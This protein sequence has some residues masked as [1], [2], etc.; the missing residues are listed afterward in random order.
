MD[1]ACRDLIERL[2]VLE[3]YK[4]LG[5]GGISGDLEALIAHPYFKG[6]DFK[7][8][9]YANVPMSEDYKKEWTSKGRA[10]A[11]EEKMMLDDS[12]LFIDGEE[13]K[14]VDPNSILK[15]GYVVKKCGWFFWKKRLL[16]MTREPSLRYYDPA[17]HQLKVLVYEGR[18]KSHWVKVC[19]HDKWASIDS[20]SSRPIGPGTSSIS[21]HSRW[22]TGSQLLTRPSVKNISSESHLKLG[23][24]LIHTLSNPLV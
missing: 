4:R 21:S 3:P 15:E 11:E 1:L 19:T 13:E 22:Q 16:R 7:T 5:S 6:I 2:V 14:P 9:A 18:M 20:M 12:S 17:T 23:Y 10:Q 24:C 8:L